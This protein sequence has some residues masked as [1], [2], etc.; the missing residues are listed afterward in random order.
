MCPSIYCVGCEDHVLPEDSA[1]GDF[2]AIDV[3]ECDE[4]DLGL[5]GTQA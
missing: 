4:P 5:E 2:S 1:L 3:C